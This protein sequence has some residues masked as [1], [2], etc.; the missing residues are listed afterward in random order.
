MAFI[1]DLYIVLQDLNVLESM[2]WEAVIVDECQSS[3]IFSHFKQ[4]KM[5]RTAMRLLLVNGQL[6]V[7]AHVF[8]F[9]HRVPYSWPPQPFYRCLIQCTGFVGWHH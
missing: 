7:C 2:K 3:R 6:K 8:L 5:L 1:I 9:V 4:I